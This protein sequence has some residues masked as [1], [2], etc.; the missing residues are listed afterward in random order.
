MKSL[1]KDKA[2]LFTVQVIQLSRLLDNRRAYTISKQVVRSGTSIGANLAESADAQSYKDFLHKVSIALKEAR[3]SQYWLEVLKE[4]KLCSITELA[5]SQNLQEIIA[6]LV[7]TR[8]TV[9]QKL[10]QKEQST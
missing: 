2:L 1:V 7:A 3:E 9:K 4:S 5:L 10:S 6:M 8:K